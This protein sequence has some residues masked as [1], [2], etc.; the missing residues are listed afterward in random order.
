[1]DPR[2]KLQSPLAI[3]QRDNFIHINCEQGRL[4][5]SILA[6]VFDVNRV[7]MEAGARTQAGAGSAFCRGVVLNAGQSKILWMGSMLPRRLRSTITLDEVRILYIDL[8][9]RR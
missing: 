3:S 5:G 1:M 4:P 7:I 6:A 9:L 2:W 8:N